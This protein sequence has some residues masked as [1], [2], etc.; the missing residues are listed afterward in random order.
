VTRAI[1]PAPQSAYAHD[2]Y[3][4]DARTNLF[5]T[6]RR[7][8][9]D[10]LALRPGDVVL[11]VGCGTGLCFEQLLEQVG[12]T[13]KVIGLDPAPDMLDL[14]ARRVREEG[15]TNVTLLASAAEDIRLDE[16]A[17]HVLFCAVHDV[18]Q[19]EAALAA[20]M[21]NVRPGGSV[22]AGGGMWAPPWAVGVNA[23]VMAI[24]A[25]FV[26]DF[27]GFDR[28]WARL[29]G[30]VADLRVERVATGGGYLASAQVPS[31]GSQPLS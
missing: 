26:R 23:M 3:L 7:R 5:S 24:H 25:P 27:T 11:D 22:A 4:Y 21:A 20:V 29:A 16:P 8:L 12:P 1:H 18:L 6:W 31:T 28:P 17:D 19:S 14:A 9:V 13:G 2:A 30:R 15:W 10:L